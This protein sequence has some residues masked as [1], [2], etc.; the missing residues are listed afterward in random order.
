MS[1]SFPQKSNICA[2]VRGNMVPIYGFAFHRT[3]LARLS[4]SSSE[5]LGP[6]RR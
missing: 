3:R 2:I 5:S 6:L 1:L 4:P